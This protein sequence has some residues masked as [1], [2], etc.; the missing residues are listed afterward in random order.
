MALLQ[1]V[2]EE[3]CIKDGS[4]SRKEAKSYKCLTAGGFT[5]PNTWVY[6]AT[7]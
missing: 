4:N 5:V 3:G 2:Q 1:K 7:V 6:T